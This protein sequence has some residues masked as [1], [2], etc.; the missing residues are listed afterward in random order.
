[1]Y[2]KNPVIILSFIQIQRL[3]FRKKYCIRTGTPLVFLK[4]K[5]K[6]KAGGISSLRQSSA[7]PYK[8]KKIK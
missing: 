8:S 3:F 1:M 7:L 6:K 4:L 5:A 2:T